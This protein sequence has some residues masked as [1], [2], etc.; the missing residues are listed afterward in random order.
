MK[1][2][3]IEKE[4]SEIEIKNDNFKQLGSNSLEKNIKNKKVQS[5]FFKED[6]KKI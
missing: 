4:S 3:N 5:I 6:I 1:N 2:T